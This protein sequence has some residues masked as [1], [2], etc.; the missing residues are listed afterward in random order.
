MQ[1]LARNDPGTLNDQD[2]D[3][4]SRSIDF[5]ELDSLGPNRYHNQG[6]G[7]TT[8]VKNPLSDPD[9]DAEEDDLLLSPGKRQQR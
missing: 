4:V 1:M 7:R 3:Q 2:A 8:V 5:V 9:T 6:R